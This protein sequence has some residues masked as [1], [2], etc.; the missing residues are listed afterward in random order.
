MIALWCGLFYLIRVAIAGSTVLKITQE[1]LSDHRVFLPVVRSSTIGG[2][3]S[4]FI[5]VED[6][7]YWLDP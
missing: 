4:S 5:Y 2:I 7:G 1:A 3:L 6:E